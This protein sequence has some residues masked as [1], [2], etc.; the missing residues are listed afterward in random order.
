MTAVTWLGALSFFEQRRHTWLDSSHALMPLPYVDADGL[1]LASSLHLV[2]KSS[3]KSNV[4]KKPWGF[5]FN[6]F[7]I[8]KRQR[9]E[10]REVKLTLLQCPT[11]HR[12]GSHSTLP[13]RED[14]RPRVRNVFG[15]TRKLFFSFERT[16]ALDEEHAARER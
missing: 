14:G 16:P 13:V 1:M 8:D 3:T 4:T 7:G 15:C 11:P 5:G 2:K 6:L 12:R 10:S 9:R